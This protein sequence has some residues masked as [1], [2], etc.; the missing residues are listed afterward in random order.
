MDNPVRPTRHGSFEALMGTVQDTLLFGMSEQR[1]Q[2]QNRASFQQKDVLKFKKPSETL[3]F[4]FEEVPRFDVQY[5][6]E[7]G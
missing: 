4:A 3:G 5:A 2:N 7:F 1:N 6:K